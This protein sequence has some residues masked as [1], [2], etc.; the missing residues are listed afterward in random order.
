MLSAARAHRFLPPIASHSC[1]VGLESI[2]EIGNK[3]DKEVEFLPE[4]VIYDV[5][6]FYNKNA[7]KG[8][9]DVEPEHSVLFSE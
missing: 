9:M 7:G 5:R 8:L 4:Q 2:P 6:E 3:W 1:N